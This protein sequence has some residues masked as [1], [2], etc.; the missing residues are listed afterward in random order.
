VGQ[1]AG[2]VFRNRLRS[3]RN[4][5][6]KISQATRR[7]RKETTEQYYRAYRKLVR[8]TQATV[9]QAEKVVGLL[10]EVATR[11]AQQLSEQME[12]FIPLVKHVIHQTVRR[13]M[14]KSQVSASE[15]I[16][17][18]FEPH[19]DIIVRGKASK[20]TEFGHKVWIDEVD[21]GIV[22]NYR[23]LRG[24]PND[25]TQWVPSLKRHN[26]PNSKPGGLG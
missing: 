9:A 17:S 1:V 8:V 25:Q 2:E 22:S 19:T 26:R 23:V 18:L 7:R 12:H 14:E 20:P 4:A 13:V 15:K 16:V 6:R 24:N 21:G 3:A 11:E 5:A 10:R